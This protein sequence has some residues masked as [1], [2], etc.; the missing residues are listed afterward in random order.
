MEKNRVGFREW[1]ASGEVGEGGDVLVF[2]F[3]LDRSSSVALILF[4]GELWGRT[5]LTCTGSED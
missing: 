2:L 5:T 4:F 3:L 1:R